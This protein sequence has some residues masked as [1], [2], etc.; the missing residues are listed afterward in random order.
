M[1]EINIEALIK[2][3]EETLSDCFEYEQS[4]DEDDELYREAAD[5]C[6]G[7]CDNCHFANSKYCLFPFGE[8]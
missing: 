4:E 2:K 6:D 3:A 7:N 1:G 8:F 5:N